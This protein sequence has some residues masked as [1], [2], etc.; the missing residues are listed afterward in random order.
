MLLKAEIF[1]CISE[2][3]SVRFGILK[4]GESTKNSHMAFHLPQVFFFRNPYKPQ[5]YLLVA[6]AEIDE[7]II[8][9]RQPVACD[10]PQ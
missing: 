9:I 7:G 3:E 2:N 6:D 1:R 8:C 4:T 10:W 5:K